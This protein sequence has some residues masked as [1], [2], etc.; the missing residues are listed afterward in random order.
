MRKVTGKHY[1]GVHWDLVEATMLTD[2][3][4]TMTIRYLH[5]TNKG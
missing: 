2:D 4:A 3:S 1:S 5:M